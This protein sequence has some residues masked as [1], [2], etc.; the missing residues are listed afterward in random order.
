MTEVFPLEKAAE[1]CERMM[2]NKA[3]FRLVITTGN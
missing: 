1:A 3:R 2:G